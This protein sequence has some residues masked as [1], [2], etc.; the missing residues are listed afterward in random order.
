MLARGGNAVD[1]AIAAAIT[2]T[3]VEPSGNGIGIGC[4]RDLWDGT[5]LHGLNASGRSPAGWTH[6]SG[7]AGLDAMPMHGWESVTVPGAVSAWVKLSDR[8]GKL[9]FERRC[10][11]SHPLR[12]TGFPGLAGHRNAVEARCRPAWRSAGLCRNLPARKAARQRPA[13]ISA[14]RDMRAPCSSLQ[15]PG[16]RR[17][18]KAS[19]PRR[20]QPM[21][22]P[23]ARAEVADLA[24]HEADW[25]GTISR[26]RR[27]DAARDTAQRAGDRRTDGAGH[28]SNTGMRDLDADDPQAMHLQIEAMKLALRDVESYVA[29]LDH[30]KAITVADLLDGGYLKSRATPRSIR[31]RPPTFMQAR[32]RTAARST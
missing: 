11:T 9:P 6:L 4:L 14:A 5:Q 20:L 32:Q 28:L 30:M 23:M 8:F 10:S 26:L 16:A 12:R 17:F 19:L 13:S 22:R 2:L 29:D 18:T 27:C 24:S 3:V 15:R 25:C 21:P 31:T 7:F 1:A